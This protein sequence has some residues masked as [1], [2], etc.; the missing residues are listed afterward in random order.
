MYEDDVAATELKA[1]ITTGETAANILLTCTPNLKKL[2]EIS[3]TPIL[4][5]FHKC[6]AYTD[7]TLS[8]NPLA[9]IES[10]LLVTLTTTS[11]TATTITQPASLNTNTIYIIKASNMNILIL[12]INISVRQCRDTNTPTL[13]EKE[14]APNEAAESD[15]MN[16]ELNTNVSNYKR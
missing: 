9:D 8:E 7:G 5:E 6:F 12:D 1:L 10:W 4:K 14:Q 13:D 15:D 2:H 11:T 16:I 3:G